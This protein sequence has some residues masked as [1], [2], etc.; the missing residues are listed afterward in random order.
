MRK[1]TLL[2][3]FK[4]KLNISYLWIPYLLVLP[5]LH[6]GKIIFYIFLMLSIHELAH[7][8]CAS[9]FHYPIEKVHVYPFGLAAQISYI[10]YGSIMKEVCI[11]AAGPLTHVCI[12]FFIHLLQSYAVISPSFA[13][14]LLMI[15]ASILMFNLLPIYPLDGGR[16]LQSFFHC[17]LRFKRAQ[18]LTY[19]CSM[20]VVLVVFYMQLLHGLS[21]TIVLVFLLLQIIL[22]WKDMSFHQLQFFRYRLQHPSHDPLIMNEKSDLYRARYNM[23]REKS[24][25]LVEEKW[26]YRR[27]HRHVSSNKKQ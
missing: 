3:H 2:R 1:Q 21:G 13:S 27:F 8:L 14:Y 20:V 23:M 6:I 24:G 7:I 10:G 17:F 15:N 9:F 26:L 16:L 19:L 25:W 12:P 4:T 18:Q 5:Y 22:S 11:I